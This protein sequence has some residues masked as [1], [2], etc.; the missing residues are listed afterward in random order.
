LKND[1]I[2]DTT[3]SKYLKYPNKGKLIVVSDLHGNLTD[4]KKY[5]SKWNCEDPNCH[6]LFTGDLIHATKQEDKSIE[7]LEDVIKKSEKHDNFNALLGNHEWA[8]IANVSIQKGNTHPKEAFEDLIKI[9]F[10]GKNPLKKY[11]SFFKKMPIIAKTSNGVFISH[12]GPFCGIKSEQNLE[13]ITNSQNYRLTELEGFLWI[14]YYEISEKSIDD[15]LDI[16]NCKA[17]VVG[18]TVVDGIKIHGNQIIIS[19]SFNTQKKAYLEIDLEAKIESKKD[20]EKMVK[21][22]M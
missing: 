22:L 6:I 10:N 2:N 17:M 18:H 20:L 12:A 4:Y 19:S 1:G 3:R 16:V 14:R 13:K 8:H 11:I 5:I 9:R 15:F 21:Y 7:I